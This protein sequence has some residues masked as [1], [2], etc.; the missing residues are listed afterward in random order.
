MIHHLFGGAISLE[1]PDGLVDASL[2]RFSGCIYN[3][4]SHFELSELRQI[5]DTQEVFLTPNS[6]VTY[7]VEILESVEQENLSEAVK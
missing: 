7:I 3:V 6:D 2:V 5:P 4:S 1:L